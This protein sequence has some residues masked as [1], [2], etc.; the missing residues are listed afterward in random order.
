ME[1]S[2][3]SNPVFRQGANKSLSQSSIVRAIAR[4]C[5]KSQMSQSTIVPECVEDSSR[6]PSQSSRS[7]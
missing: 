5:L 4:R 7:R 1:Y 3:W 2:R 6:S